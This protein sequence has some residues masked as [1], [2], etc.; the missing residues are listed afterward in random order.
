M[1]DKKQPENVEYFRCLSS[2]IINGARCN[3]KLNEGLP[4]QQLHSTRQIFSTAI[5]N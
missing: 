2:M 4:W 1:I 5:W 3:E